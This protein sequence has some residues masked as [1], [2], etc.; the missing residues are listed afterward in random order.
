MHAGQS[1]TL[2]DIMH[3]YSEDC[4][5]GDLAFTD[6]LH[7]Y[8]QCSVA[9]QVLSMIGLAVSAAITV[10]DAFSCAETIP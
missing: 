1:D 8:M 7:I 6:G 2:L 9:L 5:C 4:K 3:A 10:Y